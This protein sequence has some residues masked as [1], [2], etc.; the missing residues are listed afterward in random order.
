MTKATK[1][2]QQRTLKK[3][4]ARADKRRQLRHA[5]RSPAD[6]GPVPLDFPV[7]E[8]NTPERLLRASIQAFAFQP[9]FSAELEQALNLF[10]GE[11]AAQTQMF[12]F[13]GPEAADFQEWYFFDFVTGSSRHVIDLF[14]EEQGPALPPEQRQIVEE[15]VA[16]NHL[17]LL[18]VQAVTPGVGET[19]Q[20]LLSGELLHCNDISLSHHVRRW[21]IV[22]ARTL[23]TQ[24]RLGFTGIAQLFSPMEKDQLVG[25]AR[26]L[27]QEYQQQ[28]P[29][30]TLAGFYRMHSLQ[31]RRF[32]TE[33]QERLQHP[34]YRTAEG[35]PLANATAEY[36][37]GDGIQV[38]DRLDTAEE[39]VCVG[40][41]VKTL[42]A[43]HYVWLQRG[44]SCVP[45]A[46]PADEGATLLRTEW[47][48]G[49]GH[50]SYINLGSVTVS[51]T[52][53]ELACTS[54]E[55]LIAG[56]QLLE[57]VLAGLIAHRRD[58]FTAFLPA[59][60][61]AASA[62][63]AQRSALFD[64]E[65]RLVQN[66][67]LAREIEKLLNTPMSKLDHQT[68]RDAAKTPAGRAALEELFKAM[69]YLE[70]GDPSRS[71]TP[72]AVESIR[73]ELGLEAGGRV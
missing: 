28:Q 50:P 59:G 36:Q 13:N 39:F 4:K 33:L 26:T 46:A 1:K 41:S 49:P 3:Q 24:G 70:Q 52:A 5:S 12:S 19:V 54:R 29:Q 56:R 25:F 43:Q 18:E 31:L 14:A 15:W 2:Q 10:F 53:L 22:L 23:L 7:S 61:S 37:V 57:Q 48:I 73:R 35:H 58:Q 27:W 63:A 34:V 16:T 71:Q 47:T 40:D 11:E 62:P 30:A 9:R 8:V 21:S 38:L 65:S 44:R 32:V 60:A 20:D 69:E 64:R 51:A 6:G 66:E 68:P 17:R 67:L 45:E 72:L 42:G 55:R